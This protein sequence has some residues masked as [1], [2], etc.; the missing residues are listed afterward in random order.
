MTR[1]PGKSAMTIGPPPDP[2]TEQHARA[3]H[4]H[5]EKALDVQVEPGAEFWGWAGRTLG[6]PART[7]TGVSVWLRQ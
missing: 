2:D 6:A 4:A 1:F 5:T 3:H 7:A